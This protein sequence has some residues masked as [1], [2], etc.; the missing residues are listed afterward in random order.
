MLRIY[1]PGRVEER[2]DPYSFPPAI[3]DS[4]LL[5]LRD[6][7]EG[8][9]SRI[10]G[11]RAAFL[12]GVYGVRFAH[13]APDAASVA[14][15]G[16]FNDWN[17]R[18]HPM[19]L[20]DGTGVWELFIP[21]V[22][23]GERYGFAVRAAPDA[24]ASLLIDPFARNVEL[25]PRPAAIIG[26]APEHPWTDE[27]FLAIRRARQDCAPPV[28][29]Y[30]VEPDAWL[31]RDGRGAD[32]RTLGE[33]LPAFVSALGFT[34][35]QVRRASQ[36]AHGADWMFAP[37]PELGAPAEFAR[38][39]DECHAAG[40]GVIVEW[41]AP[42]ALAGVDEARWG[43]LRQN[44]L[45]D[46]ALHWLER[47]HVDG[48]SLRAIGGTSELLNR[49]R[50]DI[51]G[52]APG[53]LLIVE[54]PLAEARP[55][56]HI[57]RE[58][59]L[60]RLLA[61]ERGPLPGHGAHDLEGALLPA[62]PRTLAAFARREDT[63]DPLAPIRA[64]YA[65]CWLTPGM[66][67]MHMGAELG[68]HVWSDGAVAWERLDDPASIG[69]LKLV[70]DLNQ[71]LRNEAPLRLTTRVSQTMTWLPADE[72]VIAFIR[73][74]DAAAPLL[75]AANLSPHERRFHALA[76]CGGRWLELLNTDSR[77]YGG[78]DIG[79][80]GGVQASGH[81]DKPGA[82]LLDI[83]IPPCGAIILRHEC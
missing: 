51:S 63:L 5:A 32:W 12:D 59:M 39:V 7:R 10:L 16:D 37:P 9:A 30:R 58:D 34:H 1:W 24:E 21:R 70:R 74:G 4:E 82:Y 52:K 22:S 15:C 19:R 40:L 60:A 28:A 69:F 29:I 43:A 65:L 78:G 49:L 2:E 53:A 76:P 11:A 61:G 56:A 41:D 6:E 68:Q 36:R 44:V 42:Q 62:T 27:R 71:T 18:V 50:H 46:S 45:A 77:H 64:A 73:S 54:E 72:H 80:F 23:E 14:V 35:V 81:P 67:L 83:L 31:A 66:K 55:Y 38:F 17:D 26:E 33:S 8:G 25:A 75:V 79:N 3:P 13:W 20:R 48:L 47:F 57:W